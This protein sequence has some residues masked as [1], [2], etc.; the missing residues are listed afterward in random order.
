[1]TAPAHEPVVSGPHQIPDVDGRPPADLD[2]FV[3]EHHF[4]AERGNSH[5]VIE[6]RGVL[7]GE[8]VRF[9]QKNPGPGGGGKDIRVWR[10]RTSSGGVFAAE[11]EAAI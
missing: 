11:P 6:G 3:G 7:R 2:D 8:G 10:I 1:M 5:Q 4:I 9:H